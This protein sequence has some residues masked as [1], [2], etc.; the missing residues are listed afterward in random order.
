MKPLPQILRRIVVNQVFPTRWY[1]NRRRRM[2]GGGETGTQSSS[3]ADAARLSLEI[4]EKYCRMAGWETNDIRDKAVLEIGPGELL[5]VILLFAL[6]GARRAVVVDKY[7]EYRDSDRSRTILR[8]LKKIVSENVKRSWANYVDNDSRI[9]IGAGA[10]EYAHGAEFENISSDILAPPFDLICSNAVLEHVADMDGC[11]R[12]HTD[13]LRSHGL[14]VHQVD[15]RSHDA[16]ESHPLEFLEYPDWLWKA[17]SN[18]MGGPNRIRTLEYRSLAKSHGFEM[19]QL[20]ATS[21]LP[22]E[23]VERR[24]ANLARRF[25]DMTHDELRARSILFSMRKL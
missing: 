25:R 2:L 17:L 16:S 13:L 18:K 9:R 14:A 8:E 10:L 11:F 22:V 3:P 24:H 23:E 15:L 7:E 21:E 12:R 1:Q 20:I 19:V 6:C 5:G 4:F